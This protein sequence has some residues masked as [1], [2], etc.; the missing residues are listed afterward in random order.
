MVRRYFYEFPKG[1]P[2]SV[3]VEN[4]CEVHFKDGTTWA[5]FPDGLTAQDRANLDYIETIISFGKVTPVKNLMK[6]YGGG[7]WVEHYDRD[8]RLFD[9]T[10]I[11]LNKNNTRFKYNQHL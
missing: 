2:E 6:K 4:N 11:E 5:D 3:L 1:T 10:P 8:G 7:G 9:W